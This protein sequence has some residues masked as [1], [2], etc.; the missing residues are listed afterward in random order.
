M[1]LSIIFPAVHA[2]NNDV[3]SRLIFL[4]ANSQIN[5]PIPIMLI[6]MMMKYGTGN[7]R[8]I[9]LFNT[10]RISIVSFRYL[11]L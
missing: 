3:T 11:K 7:D 6:P 8:E 5:A 9:P 1:I 2:I 4:F 10:G